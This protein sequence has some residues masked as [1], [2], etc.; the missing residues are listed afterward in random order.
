MNTL[1]SSR[2]NSSSP[3]VWTGS[4]DSVPLGAQQLSWRIPASEYDLCI[5]RRELSQ[6]RFSTWKHYPLPPTMDAAPGD[7][8]TSLS[9]PSSTPTTSTMPSPLIP[10]FSE[11]DMPYHITYHYGS[12]TTSLN[13][14]LTYCSVRSFGLSFDVQLINCPSSTHSV[15][16]TPQQMTNFNSWATQEANW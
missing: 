11:T 6:H 14:L 8:A 2:I 3:H 4:P 12:P 1:T 7:K 16:S 9:A 10:H 13:S 5:W 15:S